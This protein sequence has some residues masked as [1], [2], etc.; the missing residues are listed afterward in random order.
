MTQSL[1]QALAEIIADAEK[2]KS[3]RSDGAAY[4]KKCDNLVG[5]IQR[6]FDNKTVDE[7]SSDELQKIKIIKDLV[8]KEE[9]FAQLSSK[10]R[11]PQHWL[12][13]QD[14]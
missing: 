14:V 2:L 6:V 7:L 5:R 11:D 3:Y 1:D 12:G 13:S 9:V 8:T 10:M 4:K